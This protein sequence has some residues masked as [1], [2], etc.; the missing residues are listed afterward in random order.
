MVA[1]T[2]AYKAMKLALRLAVLGFL[3]EVFFLSFW[4]LEDRF[5]FF[6]LP[7]AEEAAKM[8][9]NYSE[10]ALRSW[11]VDANFIA[12]P[13]LVITFA[14]MDLGQTAN[15]ILVSIATAMNAVLYFL[16][17]LTVIGLRQI[18]RGRRARSPS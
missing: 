7:T 11:L 17:G 1:P 13:P 2:L 15:I 3:I 6:H 9:R 8:P 10:P 12:C 14:G 4:L 5:N 16:V 18:I